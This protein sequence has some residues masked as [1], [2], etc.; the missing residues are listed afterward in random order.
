MKPSRKMWTGIALV[1]AVLTVA[2]LAAV[3]SAARGA[4][5]WWDGDQ[6]R[7]VRRA[8]AI[9]GGMIAERVGGRPVVHGGSWAMGV[10]D[11][12]RTLEVLAATGECRGTCPAM[13]MRRDAREQLRDARVARFL[14]RD[15][16]REM[17][18]K[19]ERWA[20]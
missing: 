2:E 15:R 20:L 7:A 14:A 11:L 13:V 19:L 10:S 9:V 4:Q 1:A 12:H 18:L 6:G 3:T 5:R 17:V 8:S 16:A